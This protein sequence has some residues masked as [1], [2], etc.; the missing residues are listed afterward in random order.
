V[1][2]KE[3]FSV[4][5]EW[6]DRHEEEVG[7]IEAWRTLVYE[8]RRKMKTEVT[9]TAISFSVGRRKERRSLQTL[10]EGVEQR[11]RGEMGKRKTK[12]SLEL[13][14]WTGFFTLRGEERGR[15]IGGKKRGRIF[16]H[17]RKKENDLLTL[18]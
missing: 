8:V 10:A 2:K 3:I 7:D 17:G 14:G 9:E 1:G 4:S 16:P 12:S 6:S 15:S 18:S 11:S 5:S 13:W